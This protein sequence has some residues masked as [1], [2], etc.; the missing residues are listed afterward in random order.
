MNNSTK[1]IL[2]VVAVVIV[3]GTA[4]V[5]LM[6]SSPANQ[7]ISGTGGD[8]VSGPLPGSPVTLTIPSG[9]TIQLG[10]SEG[11]VTVKN[12]YK[13]IV[14]HE[15]EFIVLEKKT[16]Y[17]ITY[18]TVRS[19][20]YIQI[21]SSAVAMAQRESEAAILGMLGINQADACRLNIMEGFPANSSYG[22]KPAK[23]SFCSGAAF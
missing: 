14:E 12:F 10:T 11:T 16:D 2:I 23:L 4:V 7:S 20:F 15:D 18:D 1:I 8:A 21:L 3:V 13:N 17:E 6:Q 5:F 9:D 22:S 19:S